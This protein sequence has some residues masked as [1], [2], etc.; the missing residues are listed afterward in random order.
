MIVKASEKGQALILITLAAI[1]LFAFAALAID[2]SM[3]FSNKRHAQNAADTSALAGALSY[4]REGKVNNIETVA[5][6]RA[7]SNGYENIS[8][9]PSTVVTVTITD[10]PEEECPGD[11]TGK[12]ITVTIE[13]YM[14]TT[15]S[16]VIGRDKIASGATATSRACGYKL[17]PLFDGH[18][19]VGLNDTRA[20]DCALAFDTG[21]SSSVAWTIEGSG[22]FSNSCAFSKEDDTVT[23]DPGLC[24]STVGGVDSHSEWNCTPKPATAYDW[25]DYVL[26]NMPPNPCTPGGIGIWPGPSDP[27]N[28]SNGVYCISDLDRY[29]STDITLNNATLYVTDDEFDIKFAGGGGFFGTATKA[30]TYTGSD[31]Y[32]DYYMVVQPAEFCTKFSDNTNSQR[33]EWRGN[34]TGTFYGTVFAPTACL[35]LRGNGA[36]EGM[37]SQ[38]I[39]WIVGSNGDADVYINYK[40]NE[41]H[42][43]PFHPNISLLE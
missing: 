3:A 30:G 24:V 1:G 43:I 27:P 37:H 16:K 8:G 15:F 18:A 19:I 22:V 23:F 12:D 25:E 2:G 7:K 11:A 32:A 41:N 28:F 38:I 26:A 10:V 5:L 36:A 29:D 33:I 9:D 20:P 13:S 6:A 17:V 21:N 31:D 42:R 34:G 40:A 35:D 14:N 39:G 4:A